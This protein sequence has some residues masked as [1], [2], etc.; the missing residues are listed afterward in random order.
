MKKYIKLMR[1][2]HYIKN[3]LVFAAL[4]CS[5]QI[6]NKEKLAACFLGFFSF[7]LISSV[8]YIINDICDKD[9][10]RKH[11]TKCTRPIASGAV[12]VKSAWILCAVLFVGAWVCNFLIFNLLGTLLLL[13]YFLLNLAYSF[14]M[15]NITLVD[16]MILVAG[17]IIRIL[18][19]A[20]VTDIPISGWLYLTV[21]VT[22]SYFALGKR[23]NEYR[24]L[25]NGQTRK[26]LD[27]Y[28]IGFLDKSMVVCLTLA[29][30]FYTLWSM[31]SKTV[32]FYGNNYLI[33]TVPIVLLITMRY[34]L[35][36]ERESDGD[37]I[38][39]LIHDK[40][41]LLLCM[42]YMFCALAILYI[43]RYL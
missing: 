9:N 34:S 5:G 22:A 30:A 21:I 18:Y 6:F 31:D 23:R 1:I 36:I 27:S 32:A 15:K 16:I 3:I 11:P 35:K 12:S 20:V 7:C 38:E 33:F 43:P 28:P 14:G 4:A 19:G 25:G 40:F 29:N 42:V 2:H 8:V 13:S 37:P 39:V 26:V 10:D 24:N 41:L 17:Y